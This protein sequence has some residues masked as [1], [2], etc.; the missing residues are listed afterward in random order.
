MCHSAPLEGKIGPNLTDKYWIA[1]KG[2][3]QDIYTTVSAGRPEKGMPA[4]SAV[5]KED[6]VRAV[7]AFVFSKKGSNPANPKAPQGEP[8]DN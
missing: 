7:T 1:G 2:S 5:L 6:E 8:V 4:W 3:N